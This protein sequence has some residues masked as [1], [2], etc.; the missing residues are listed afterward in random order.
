MFGGAGVYRE[1]VMFALVSDGEVYLK[2]DA[3]SRAEFREAGRRPFVYQKAGKAVEMSY[4]SLPEAAI[5]DSELLKAFAELS[6][7]AARSRGR[8]RKEASSP[9]PQ[10][11]TASGRGS[12]VGRSRKAGT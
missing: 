1:G 8:P 2:G 10:E 7:R 4:W 3:T 9:T 6:L 5:D 12:R 11:S